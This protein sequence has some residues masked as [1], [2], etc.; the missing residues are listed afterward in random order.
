MCSSK[1]HGNKS[2]NFVASSRREALKRANLR[3]RKAR[4]RKTAKE[5]GKKPNF[6]VRYLQH[7]SDKMMGRKATSVDDEDDE[8]DYGAPEVGIGPE[9][10]QDDR[11]DE[12]H[13]DGAGGAPMVF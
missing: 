9:N 12:D 8:D 3:A 6:T 13:H 2:I 4:Q 11:H 1:L 10:H 7:L 5:T